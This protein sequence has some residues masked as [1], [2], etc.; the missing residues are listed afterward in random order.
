MNA[1][2]YTDTVTTEAHTDTAERP[3]L[4]AKLF[5]RSVMSAPGRYVILV[6]LVGGLGTLGS[7]FG[8]TA[9]WIIFG[10]ILTAIAVTNLVR[11]MPPVQHRS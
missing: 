3:S 4:W 5:R 11:P 7:I 2:N 10:S 6:A 9:E 8:S 1:P